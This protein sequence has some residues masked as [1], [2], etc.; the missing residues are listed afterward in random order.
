MYWHVQRAF[1]EAVK[2]KSLQVA[3]HIIEDLD[4]DLR[5]DS[6]KNL[7]HMFLFTCSMA[8]TVQDLDLQ[9]INRQLV[10]YIV[11]GLKKEV[12]PMNNTNG[13]TP[14]HIACD[15]L[16]DLTIIE[17]LVDAGADVNSVNNDDEMPLVLVRRRLKNDPEN[18][19]LL[20]IEEYLV[21]KGAK[22][23]WRN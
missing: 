16:T 8:E 10:R 12:D 5:H 4:L 3:E 6:F 21:R 13:S 17:V 15:Q 1:K 2:Y 14:L 7:L 20:D 22:T 19:N 18:V 11:R 9:E 23:Q